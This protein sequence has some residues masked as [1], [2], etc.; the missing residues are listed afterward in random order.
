MT[1]ELIPT[2][3]EKFAEIKKYIE[4]PAF[5]ESMLEIE[6]RLQEK[7]RVIQVEEDETMILASQFRV[8]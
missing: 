3:L 2:S 7:M 8:F 4:S 5:F 1:E 6:N